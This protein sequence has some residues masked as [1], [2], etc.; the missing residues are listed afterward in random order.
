VHHATLK[1]WVKEMLAKGN[2][3]PLELF[4]VFR[5]RIAKMD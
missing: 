4:G 5:R 3:L 1:A 2:E